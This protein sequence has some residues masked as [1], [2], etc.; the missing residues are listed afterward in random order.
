MKIRHI[1]I[2]KF[3][4]EIAPAEIEGIVSG[5][6][7]LPDLIDDIVFYEVG[8][9]T[10]HMQPERAAD[11]GIVSAFADADAL[12]RYQDHPAHLAVARRLRAASQTLTIVDYEFET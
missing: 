8:V 7:E 9:D 4:P 2:A 11:L 1:V 5:L 12:Q 6:R 10:W 3:K